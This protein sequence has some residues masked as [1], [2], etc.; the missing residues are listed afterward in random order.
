[1]AKSL[2][3][4]GLNDLRASDNFTETSHQN[5]TPSPVRERR[6]PRGLILFQQEILENNEGK[7]KKVMRMRRT[8]KKIIRCEM[9]RSIQLAGVWIPRGTQSL[10]HG[11]AVPSERET[12]RRS[13]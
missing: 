8:E 12:E 9:S 13:E 4:S 1:M 10:Q 2:R 11:R 7:K 6:R 5:S 3:G